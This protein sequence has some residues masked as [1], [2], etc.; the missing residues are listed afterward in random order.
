MTNPDP[1]FIECRTDFNVFLSSIDSLDQY[2]NN[3]FWEFSVSLPRILRLIQVPNHYWT[4]CLTDIELLGTNDDLLPIPENCVVL[5]SIVE[6]TIARG[7][8]KRILRQIWRKDSGVQGSLFTPQLYTLNTSTLH[9]ISIKIETNK[10][11]PLDF[12]KWESLIPP[13]GT[14]T[15]LEVAL[16]LN[17]QLLES[18]L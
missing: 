5:T 14:W 6:P 2:P 3:R 13:E 15:Q 7:C 1:F 17:F 4:V 18:L 12:G 10:F 8:F 9:T 11:E 16:T